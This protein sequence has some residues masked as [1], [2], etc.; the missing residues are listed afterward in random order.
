MD[1][2]GDEPKGDW[3]GNIPPSASPLGVLR[4]GPST[5]GPNLLE[6]CSS[7]KLQLYPPTITTVIL[8]SSVGMWEL[9]PHLRS[10]ESESAFEQH[11]LVIH[12]H[13]TE[14]EKH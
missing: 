1:S 2:R 8:G 4:A 3:V 14:F 12:N 9:R 10:G 6:R 5:W 11:S 13:V 7:V